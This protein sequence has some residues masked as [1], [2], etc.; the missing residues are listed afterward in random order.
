MNVQSMNKKERVL[1]ATTEIIA[2]EGVNGSP[3]SQI[4]REANVATGTIYHHFNSKEEI[5]NE[6]YLNIKKNFGLVIENRKAK[7]KGSKEEFESVWLGFYYYFIENPMEFK[8]IQQIEHCPI[9]TR[10][11]NIECEKYILPIFEFYQ[12]GINENVF[13]NMDTMLMGNLIY[14]NIMTIIKLNIKG[15]EITNK[16]LK[17]AIDF[18]WRAIAK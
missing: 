11:T 3:M 18:S 17:Q 15:F 5:I 9:I 6:I 8:F 7:K 1:K 12:K 16:I 14:D 10:K 2:V 13:V 4:A